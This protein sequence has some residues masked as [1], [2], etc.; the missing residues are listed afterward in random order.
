MLLAR[1]ALE[2]V[3]VGEYAHLRNQHADNHFPRP[4]RF[5]TKRMECQRFGSFPKRSDGEMLLTRGA[6]EFIF[7]GE[8]MQ[9]SNIQMRGALFQILALLL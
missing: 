5:S 1:G 6:L 9:R 8:N 4:S 7:V 2:L 3:F